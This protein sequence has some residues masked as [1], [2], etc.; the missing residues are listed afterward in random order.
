MDYLANRPKGLE[1]INYCFHVWILSQ[2]GHWLVKCLTGRIT[3]THSQCIGMATNFLHSMGFGVSIAFSPLDHTVSQDKRLFPLYLPL[4]LLMTWPAL[5]SGI[6]ERSWPGGSG[7]AE[8]ATRQLSCSPKASGPHTL[9][10]SHTAPMKH[11]GAYAGL[12][13]RS[14]LGS[15]S[16]PRLSS[17][18]NLR[19]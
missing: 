13:W 10:S 6:W 11:R 3:F 18:C 1:M 16:S 7:W 17:Q 4:E 9:R 5:T 15:K 19:L 14:A 2:D 8:F 12:A